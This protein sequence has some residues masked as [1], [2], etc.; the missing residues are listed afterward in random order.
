MK[1]YTNRNTHFAV[2]LILDAFR[3]FDCHYQFE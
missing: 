1:Y 2:Q 3:F